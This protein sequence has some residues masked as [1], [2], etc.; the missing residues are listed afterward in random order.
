[1]FIYVNVDKCR[2][3]FCPGFRLHLFWIASGGL[4]YE[5]FLHADF[6]AVCP[7]HAAVAGFA[8][9]VSA[10][11]AFYRRLLLACVFYQL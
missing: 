7:V 1:M 3:G 10:Y 4:V 2:L 8:I 11:L 9:L 5:P 6:L